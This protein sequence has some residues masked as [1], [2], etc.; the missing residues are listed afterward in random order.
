MHENVHGNFKSVI[1]TK[2][3]YFCAWVK[4]EHDETEDET[5]VFW[6]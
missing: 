2:I 6:D 5:E 3:P 1:D 4:K